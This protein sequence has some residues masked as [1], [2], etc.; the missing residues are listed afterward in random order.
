MP[1]IYLYDDSSVLKNKLD[2]DD[3]SSVQNEKYKKY[4][5]E[6]YVPQPHRKRED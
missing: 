6:K 2:M 4:Q 3:P 5:T 1:D